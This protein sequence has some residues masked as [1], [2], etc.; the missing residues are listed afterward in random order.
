MI[1][2]I[3]V[4]LVLQL[5]GEALSTAF[6]LVLPGPVIGMVLLLI[7]LLLRDRWLRFRAAGGSESGSDG[8]DG[9]AAADREP[10]AL[11]PAIDQVTSGLLGNLSLL[12][13]PAGVG[14]ILHIDLLREAWLPLLAALIV[15]T[16]LA[17]AVTALVIDRLQRGVGGGGGHG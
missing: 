15:S 7:G 13:V 11:P 8:G 9:R 17:V 1:R 10:A 5:A 3:T 16:L 4:L 12:F 6:S 2:F 14:V